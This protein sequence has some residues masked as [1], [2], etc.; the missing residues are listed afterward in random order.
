MELIY[1]TRVKSI[2]VDDNELERLIEHDKDFD[3]SNDNYYELCR[4]Y[5]NEF[6]AV[7]NRRVYN[8]KNHLVSLEFLN[9]NSVGTVHTVTEFVKIKK[10]NIFR[11]MIFLW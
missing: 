8:D 9:E 1:G 10:L 6:A 4:K 11:I 5:R 7:K 3:Y 2:V